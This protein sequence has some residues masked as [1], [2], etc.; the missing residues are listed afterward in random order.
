MAQA[1][2][3]TLVILQIETES[4]VEHVEEIARTPGVDC[5]WIGQFDLS[6]AMGIP[7]AFED[8]RLRAAEDH[9]LAVCADAGVAAGVLVATAETACAMATRGFR[10]VAV[11]TDIGLYGDALRDAIQHARSGESG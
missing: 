3:Q 7:G 2:H 5:L 4:G 1:E 11:G 9:V 10:M 6:I 8:R